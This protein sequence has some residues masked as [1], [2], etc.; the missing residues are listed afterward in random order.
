MLTKYFQPSKVFKVGL[1]IG[2]SAVL[3]ALEISLYCIYICDKDNNFYLDELELK[4]DIQV[5]K[6]YHAI[7]LLGKV[8]R[9]ED[10]IDLFYFGRCFKNNDPEYIAQLLGESTIL[11]VDDFEGIEKLKNF[12]RFNS[13]FLVHLCPVDFLDFYGSRSVTA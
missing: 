12:F 9:K 1:F 7:E 6:K 2:R 11:E 3:T 5:W 13:Y 8:S 10:S 4:C